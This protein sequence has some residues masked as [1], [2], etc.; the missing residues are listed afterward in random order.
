MHSIFGLYSDGRTLMLR[1]YTLTGLLILVCLA[2]MLAPALIDAR[3]W[4]PRKRRMKLNLGQVFQ[5]GSFLLC[6]FLALR[7]TEGLDGT[8]FSGGWLTGPLL[9][10]AALGTVLF[11]LALVLTFLFPRVAALL[12]LGSSLLCLPLYCFFLAPVPFNRV[13]G[14][15]HEFKVQPAPGFHLH[16]W[17]L[18]A[19]L[20]SVVAVYVCVR[21]LVGNSPVGNPVGNVRPSRG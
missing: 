2:G 11:I 1:T 4:W 9:S 17:P 7:I 21:R 5:A 18:T 6:I 3:H 16:V 8:E 15:G 14:R 19:L 12:G 13:F 10:M 20:A